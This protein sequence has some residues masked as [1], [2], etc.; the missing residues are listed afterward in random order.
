MTLLS[1]NAGWVFAARAQ[2]TRA[3]AV[4]SLLYV[5]IYLL[6]RVEQ[7]ALLIGAVSSFAV[8]ASVMYVT[9][10]LDWYHSLP[11]L[12]GEKAAPAFGLARPNL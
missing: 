10:K 8:V 3:F 2:Q 5:L 7:D 4:F 1:V 11:G 9:R 6:L 12:N